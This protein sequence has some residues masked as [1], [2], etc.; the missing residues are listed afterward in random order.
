M[1]I[2]SVKIVDEI[3]NI[4]PIYEVHSWERAE[5]V[6]KS[7]EALLKDRVAKGETNGTS[8]SFEVHGFVRVGE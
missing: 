2:Y 5:E 7:A 8:F 3:N 1:Y 4:A 6:I